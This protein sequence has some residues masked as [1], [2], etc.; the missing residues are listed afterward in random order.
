MI[1]IGYRSE[2]YSNQNENLIKPHQENT[3]Q[4]MN[5]NQFFI[6]SENIS[7]NNNKFILTFLAYRIIV[8]IFVI[9]FLSASIIPVVL[10]ELKSDIQI[11]SIILGV[12]ISLLII[13]FSNNK[14]EIIK[15]IS[16]NK[17]IIKEI[18]FL[19]FPK[20]IINI[21][22]ENFHFYFE[23]KQSYGQDGISPESIETTIINDYKNLVDIDLDKSAIKQKPA[24]FFY[25][26]DN[27]TNRTNAEDRYTLELN[28]FIGKSS[29]NYENPLFFNINNYMNKNTNSRNFSYE[30]S[31]Y[32]KFSEH[33]FT[34]HFH[35]PK[36]FSC[37]GVTLFVFSFI[38]N[39]FVVP[40][41]HI[42]LFVFQKL[43]GIYIFVVWNIIL[44]IIYKCLKTCF[45]KIYRMDCIF[46]RDFDRIFIGLVKYN[47]KSYIN[48]FEYEINNIDRFL[49]EKIGNKNYNLM[50]VF[51]DDQRLLI[52]NI[53]KSKEDL[54]GLAF[55]L[56]ERIFKNK[57]I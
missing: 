45:D 18:N 22:L 38:S 20:K 56:N 24:K 29:E 30:L 8:P 35:S 34:Y 27:I 31:K 48:T 33:L 37:I 16:N 11:L 17:I 42:F 4:R 39:L 40:S 1:R 49:L 36:I 6:E 9:I 51:K 14:L 7:S 41:I 50:V 25:T 26:Y 32:M 53:K 15:D 12:I 57:G 21:D 2:E 10:I 5:V 19:C 55:L 52:C 54:E 28:N 47:Q 46:S 23:K 3:Q 43:Y 44:Y 13:I